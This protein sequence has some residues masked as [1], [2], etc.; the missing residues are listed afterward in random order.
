MNREVV[1]GEWT[2]ST[3]T[4][5]A[6]ELLAREGYHEDAVTRSYYAI[7]HA[8]KA[9]LSIHDLEA[10]SHA[11]VR[12][13]FGKYLVLSGAIERE[14]SKYLGGSLDDRLAADYD[15]K[16]FFSLDEA[17]R[18]CRRAGEFIERIR[19]YLIENGLNDDELGE[20]HGGG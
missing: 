10:E 3:R 20:A 11:G 15:I 7:L 4:L 14:W 16:V 18:E 6:A 5:L 8:A 12:R 13:M 2:R 19:Q 9:A 17:Q 1:L